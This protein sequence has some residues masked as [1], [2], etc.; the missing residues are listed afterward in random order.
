MTDIICGIIAF[1]AGCGIAAFNNFMTVK[2]VTQNNAASR[3]SAVYMLRA[4]LNIG[5]L[6]AAYLI[7]RKTALN[8]TALLIGAA[9]GLSLATV[10]FALISSKK[11]KNPDK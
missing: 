6:L 1:A 7:G 4:V 5:L 2:A 11:L 3:F 8:M 9:L 10:V